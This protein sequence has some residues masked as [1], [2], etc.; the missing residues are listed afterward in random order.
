LSDHALAQVLRASHQRANRDTVKQQQVELAQ[1]VR[2]GLEQLGVELSNTEA[3]RI[4][5]NNTGM[6]PIERFFEETYNYK[7]PVGA[8]VNPGGEDGKDKEGQKE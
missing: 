6:M 1:A 2:R 5:T 8:H 7:Y 4:A 3:D